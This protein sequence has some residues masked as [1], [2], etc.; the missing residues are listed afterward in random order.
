MRPQLTVTY[1]PPNNTPTT[2]IVSA[3]QRRDGSGIVDIEATVADADG[4][5]LSLR[6]FETD[7]VCAGDDGPLT[8]DS[9]AI[10]VYE[11]VEGVPDVDE[12]AY[13]QI[14]SGTNTRLITSVGTN[15]IQFAW[16]A[17]VDSP[18][19]EHITNKCF[20]VGVNDGGLSASSTY[21]ATIDTRAPTAP[22]GVSGVNSV[23]T[24]TVIFSGWG[25]ACD[26]TDAFFKEYKVHYDTA[27]SVTSADAAWTSSTYNGLGNVTCAGLGGSTTFGGL[28]TGTTYYANL[29]AY[30]EYG[31]VSSSTNQV[32]FTTDVATP[33]VPTVSASTTNK[34]ALKVVINEGGNT[35][36]I[37]YVV[38][39]TTDG[40]ACDGGG[41]VKAD[42]T[43]GSSGV[44][45]NYAAWGGASGFYITG[46]SVNESYRILVQA[47][48]GS[49]GGGSVISSSSAP[50]YTSA[51][52]VGVVTAVDSTV[53][54]TLRQTLS[55]IDDGSGSGLKIMQ[56]VGCDGSYNTTIVDQPSSPLLSPTSTTNVLPNTCY[57][58]QFFSYNAD[59]V[60][61]VGQT[62][63]SNDMT[64]PPTQPQDVSAQ[65]TTADT[66]T[67][68]WTDVSGAGSYDV[69]NSATG[70]ILSGAVEGTTYAQSGLAANTQST[71]VVRARNANGVGVASSAASSY[72][73]ASTPVGLGHTNQTADGMRWTWTSSGQSSF[74]VTNETLGTNSGWISDPYW[75]ETGLTANTS[76]TISVKA[77]NGA[78]EETGASSIIRYTSQQA[79]TSVVFTDVQDDFIE[80]VANGTFENLGV[81]SSALVFDNGDGVLQTTIN[82]SGLLQESGLI[83]NTSY[84]YTVYATNGDG[85][86]TS[87]VSDT[88]TTL[89]TT[90]GVISVAATGAT[91]LTLTLSA[92]G[93]P[94]NTNVRLYE[95]S[96]GLYVDTSAK[97][98]T[99]TSDSYDT[100]SQWGTPGIIGLTPNTQYRFSATA[101]NSAEV[102]SSAS[103]LSDAV[104]TLANPPLN[105][106]ATANSASQITVTWGRNSNPTGTE[107]YV[108]NTTAGINSGWITEQSYVATGLTCGTSYSFE[109]K[110]RNIDL[111]ET[112]IATVTGATSACPSGVTPAPV[113]VSSGAA[114]ATLLPPALPKEGLFSVSING[115]AVRTVSPLVTLTLNGGDDAARMSISEDA[116]FTGASQEPYTDTKSFR[117]SKQ[118]GLKQVFAKFYT[119][120]GVASPVVSSTITLASIPV[121]TLFVPKANEVIKTLPFVVSGKGEPHA[122]V[123]VEIAGSVYSV[124]A[125]DTGAYNVTILDQLAPS[126]YTLFASQTTPDGTSLQTERNI[127]YR[128]VGTAVEESE[129]EQPVFDTDVPVAQS[130]T[131]PTPAAPATSPT[132]SDIEQIIAN[133]KQERT[134]FI[135]VQAPVSTHFTRE[136]VE[137]ID[138]GSGGQFDLIVRPSAPVHSITARLYADTPAQQVTQLEERGL[139]G[140][141]VSWFRPSVWAIVE[142]AETPWQA[143]YVFP[144]TPN[145]AI[146]QHTITLP[147][148]LASGTYRLVLTFNGEDGSRTQLTKKVSVVEKGILKNTNGDRA[149]RAKVTV[150]RQEKSG[151]Y[152][153]WP[154]EA[155]GQH[156]PI[157]ADDQG[158]Y[159]IYVPAGNYYVSVDDAQHE[160]YQSGVYVFDMPGII[161]DTFSLTPKA[162]DPLYRFVSWII[163]LF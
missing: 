58:Y 138:V 105:P 74:Y 150:Y 47:R 100:F 39:K 158:E 35:G 9:Y 41:F 86:A 62:S 90:P 157:L 18:D 112:D 60:L 146:Y 126:A 52:P 12:N 31:N 117:L 125:D 163:E 48:R 75:D 142:P 42:N 45:Q 88:T 49:D 11:D 123:Q 70:A 59:G 79:P 97:T 14:G 32:N 76:Y 118:D 81:V 27:A 17:G 10:A 94:T 155:F 51:G 44:W 153:V 141:V 137:T 36:D 148:S 67:W 103:A 121:P 91:A 37:E 102:L 98:L 69:Y 85:D 114:P 40:V 21:Q 30:D 54:T 95:S 55:W 84:T 89:A 38:C 143:A 140:R 82:P 133:V 159:L 33:G 4:D 96:T 156:N 63:V 71:I 7:S 66:I 149:E 162:R 147:V 87:S 134:A 101:K 73:D 43:L 111:V 1:A 57:R 78:L 65:S 109:V 29:F 107:F 116:A 19:T 92:N 72:T 144:V 46:L 28:L 130:P 50:V 161:H 108:D 61:N 131:A 104:Y 152:A 23:A 110:A 53:T 56:D 160:P 64:T 2:T 135:V 154:G 119:E 99:G 136:Q 145:D 129:P 25:G 128:P 139:W 127:L 8:L 22:F 15:T 113:V 106:L 24:S 83:P 151:N 124:K 80:V 13:Y 115:G 77:R 120:T 3:I 6:V 5:D 34:N 16:Q 93:N 20:G 68:T 122:T 132:Q 26:S